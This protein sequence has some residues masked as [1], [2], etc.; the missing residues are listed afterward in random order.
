MPF[1]GRNFAFDL[2]IGVRFFRWAATLLPFQKS[3]T[4]RT[5]RNDQDVVRAG[6][7]CGLELT[8]DN[9]RAQ[10]TSWILTLDFFNIHE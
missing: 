8:G 6:R 3:L 2:T 10:R 9:G 7:D 4:C 1:A 5:I